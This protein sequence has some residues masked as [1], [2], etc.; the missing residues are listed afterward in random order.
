MGYLAKSL[1]PQQSITVKL[2]TTASRDEVARSLS[3]YGI[4]FKVL[5]LDKPGWTKIGVTAPAG[6]TPTKQEGLVVPE[7]RDVG[8]LVLTRGVHEEIVVT[9]REGGG[10]AQ[11]VLDWLASDGLAL[12]VATVK[13][14]QVVVHVI[15]HDDLL[16]LRDELGLT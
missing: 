7:G 1:K 12:N 8:R 13:E 3:Q 14:R 11:D 2:S 10:A 5:G 16:I 9:L 6:L 15:A 4:R